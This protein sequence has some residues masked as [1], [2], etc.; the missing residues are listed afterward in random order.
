MTCTYR[1]RTTQ[2]SN[3]SYWGLLEILWKVLTFPVLHSN[4]RFILWEKNVWISSGSWEGKNHRITE[5]L[6]LERTSGDLPLQHPPRQGHPEHVTQERLQ[7]GESPQLPLAACSSALPPSRSWGP[8]HFLKSN[9]VCLCPHNH[10]T[11]WLHS[12]FCIKVF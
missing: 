8:T 6:G 4:I 11:I 10:V 7:R 1:L 3:T 5:S 2:V 12:E 9:N